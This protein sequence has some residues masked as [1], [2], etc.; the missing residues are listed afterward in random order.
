MM[1][2]SERPLADPGA[3]IHSTWRVKLANGVPSID[4]TL[5][6]HATAGLG[7]EDPFAPPD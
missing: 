7:Q 1:G 5:A 3:C 2:E 6:P 4:L